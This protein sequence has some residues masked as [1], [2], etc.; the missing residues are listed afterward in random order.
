DQERKAACARRGGT[1]PPEG[2]RADRLRPVGPE[3]L[4]APVDAEAVLQLPHARRGAR[5]A[6]R[7]RSARSEGRGGAHAWRLLLLGQP[8]LIRAR[9][10]G[11]RARVELVR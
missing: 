3:G 10:A 9:P 4:P 8:L 11:A 1:S 5:F 7:S 6:G 2:P